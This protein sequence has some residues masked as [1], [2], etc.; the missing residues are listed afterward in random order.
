MRAGQ[1]I[2]D[3]FEVRRLAASGGMGDVY[4]CDDL[5]TGALVA[6]KLMHVA[7]A[8]ERF[9]REAS[10]LAQLE[11]PSIVRYVAHGATAEG[12][13][14]LA[15]EWLDGEDLAARLVRARLSV[16]AGVGLV[17]AVAG[18]LVWTHARGILHRDLK[19]SNIFL[20][21]GDAESPRL[22][23]FGI[24]R[25]RGGRSLTGTGA[26]IGSP[27]YM[28]PEQAQGRDDL[29]ER[30]D[31]FSLGCVLYE[32]LT[33]TPAFSGDHV[34]AVI[35]KVLA[36]DPPPAR[37]IA[38]EIPR[39]LSD[40]VESMLAKEPARRPASAAAVVEA[41]GSLRAGG[42][43]AGSLGAAEAFLTGREQRFVS[44]VLAR[45]REESGVMRALSANAP[46]L[47]VEEHTARR[48][49][50]TALAPLG[51]RAQWT[52]DRALVATVT[53]APTAREQAA[54]A[55]R[56]A[57]LVRA[58]LPGAAV[59][60]VTGR[61]DAA[62]RFPAGAAIDRA[63]RL[64]DE[65]SASGADAA[66]LDDVTLGLLDARFE[67]AGHQLRRERETIDPARRLLGRATPCVGRDRELG[68]LRAIVGEC[69]GEPAARAVLVTAPAGGG[70]SRL[71]HE[72]LLA[73]G[74]ARGDLR[75]IF[76][77]GDQLAAGSPFAILA[78]A[79]R[80]RIGLFDGEPL[81]E[82][83]QKL[84]AR[85]AE[86]VAGG[87][88]ARV[89]EFLGEL[90]GLPSDDDAGVQ[91]RAA[92]H[93]KLVM[94]EQIRRAVEAWIAAETARGPVLLVLE[95]LHWGDAPSVRCLDAVLGAL[96]D[97]PLLVL[98]TG[99]PEVHRAFPDLWSTRGL[100][101]I[102]L[103]ELPRRAT[104][105]FVRE[106][107][108]AEVEGSVIERVLDR[109]G[110]NPFYLEELIRAQAEGRGDAPPE[111]VVAMVQARLEALP[112]SARQALRA[113]SIFGETFWRSGVVELLGGDARTSDVDERF[114]VLVERETIVRRLESRFNGQPEY[115]FRHA[116]IRDAAYAMLVDEDRRLGHRLAA[117]WLEGVGERDALTMGEHLE[118]GGEPQRAVP[119]YRAAAGHAFEGSDLDGVVRA[120]ERAIACGAQG[121][122]LG[123]LL[124]LKAETHFWR[125]EAHDAGRDVQACLEL[126]TPGSAFW[127]QA[128][129]GIVITR[130]QAG[131]FDEAH[132]RLL[133][134]TEPAKTARLTYARGAQTNV[135]TL[136]SLGR[137][138]EARQFLARLE[139][140]TVLQ[141]TADPLA[142]AHAHL[143]RA[144]AARALSADA[145]T[146][147][148]EGRAARA[149]FIAAGGSPSLWFA[150]LEEMLSR[151]ALGDPALPE[152]L[153]AVVADAERQRAAVFLPQL[154]ALHALVLA[155]A[156]RREAAI[157]SAAR[158]HGLVP[159]PA[160]QVFAAH[161]L[162]LLG[163]AHLAAGDPVAAER[164]ARRALAAVIGAPFRAAAGAVL[165]L[166]LLRRGRAAEALAAAREAE[167]HARPLSSIGYEE[168][169]LYL[170]VAEAR[171]A[172]GD[173]QGG[174]AA[175]ERA[176]SR[177]LARAA[178]IADASLRATYL[179]A[180]PEHARLLALAGKED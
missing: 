152:E 58:A 135:L 123:E 101:E 21:D 174:R 118:R 51:V 90:V 24:A 153:A 42:F 26:A 32:C 22:L 8:P 61:V 67:V 125:G 112:P 171:I 163:E 134:A 128:M 1:L 69:F 158:A 115:R 82:G 131:S 154:S 129:G 47:P 31:V 46:T 166:A 54:N 80:A 18:A 144:A 121:E 177:L 3:R 40:F 114:A 120:A 53:G 168:S 96:V 159:E 35:C 30:A 136:S 28:A 93:D 20:A 146:A 124:Y 19:P 149:S 10:F 56:C 65:V 68:A 85:V 91:L 139:H 29:D 141:G 88:A 137:H 173:R 37:E 140:V 7:Q 52:A 55:A 106:M 107:L 6:V 50:E 133:L 138:D 63:A 5:A 105:A 16:D 157:E 132:A 33:G 179:D 113:A 64:L 92:R 117:T 77:R 41:L 161:G 38:P 178:A 103:G 97:A 2:A 43:A 130:A 170:A 49:L 17:T 11:H 81:A 180:V 59:A 94:G 27:G 148:V 89:A 83:R 126:L 25:L 62:S 98:A 147:L 99:R 162:V 150:E 9:L 111:T 172:S 122:I 86:R 14:F 110:G 45:P 143:G 72:L 108:G 100:Q 84:R 78:R 95:D 167:A 164:A 12:T 36:Y 87:D 39:A 73:E 155:R 116:L 169:L 13:P 176:R 175:A 34:V 102:R 104:R 75:S 119:W 48:L 76:G 127:C 4:A 60:V 79:V 15:M 156:G 151:A 74:A 165:A 23:D 70:K 57:L 160:D 109:A 66:L 44:M 142:Q 145:W 71:V